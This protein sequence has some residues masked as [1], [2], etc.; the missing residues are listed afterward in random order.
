MQ[1]VDKYLGL[2]QGRLVVH[3]LDDYSCYFTITYVCSDLLCQYD[4]V[5]LSTCKDELVNA[6]SLYNLGSMIHR[7]IVISVSVIAYM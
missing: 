2:F 3:P 5:L 7:G 6:S 4:Q 1:D